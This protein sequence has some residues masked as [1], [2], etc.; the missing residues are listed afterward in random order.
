MNGQTTSQTMNRIY[1]LDNLRSFMIF[2]VVLLHAGLVYEPTGMAGY[3]WIVDDPATNGFVEQVNLV[4][5]IFIMSVIF[6]ISG[7]LTPLS[8]QKKSAWGFIK[9]KF[10]RLMIPWAV[11]M[12]TLIPLYKVIF[13]YS[14]GLP[15]A[16]WTTYFHFNNGIFSQN[17]LW[18]LP[19]LFYFDLVYL[20]IT[21]V[22]IRLPQIDVKY[23]VAI[24]FILGVIYSFLV[25]MMQ[26]QGWTKN[27]FI[28]FQNERIL[29]YW[30]LFLLGGQCLKQRVF[31]SKPSRAL[32]I[33]ILCTVW[34]PIALYQFFYVQAFINPGVYVFSEVFDTLLIW[35]NFHLSLLGLLYILIQT[36]RFLPDFG[37]IGRYLSANSYHV[38]IV[39]TIIIGGIALLLLKA[40]LPSLVKFAILTAVTYIL[41]NLFVP[42]FRT[43]PALWRAGRVSLFLKRQEN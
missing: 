12:L 37:K 15:Q 35:A 38:Y 18:F 6:F 25:D 2:L 40:T 3:F 33:V 28:N 8:L 42:L 41:S 13:L 23:M 9:T 39:H 4:L 24:V 17:W 34:I 36:F 31:A 20:L 16:H 29:I 27:G 21:R 7:Y 30:M 22:R 43:R 26:L 14:R 5:D 19:V 11:S 32:Y 1:F 10:K